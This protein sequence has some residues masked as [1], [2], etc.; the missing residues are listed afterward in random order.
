MVILDHPARDILM[1]MRGGSASSRERWGFTLRRWFPA[2]QSL[3][4]KFNAL[5]MGD[6]R[7]PRGYVCKLL[8]RKVVKWS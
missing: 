5:R 4:Q 1:S 2:T 7:Q 8:A 6:K 3:G